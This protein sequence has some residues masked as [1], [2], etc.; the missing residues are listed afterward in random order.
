A[1]RNKES[2]EQEVERNKKPIEMRSEKKR[3]VEKNEELIE[4]RS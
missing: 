2:K 1:K 4:M 3:G